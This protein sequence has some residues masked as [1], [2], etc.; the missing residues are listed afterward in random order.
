M[1]LL[2]SN[3]YI[4][5]AQIAQS[6]IEKIDF[7]LCAGAGT[8]GRQTLEKF[9]A[10]NQEK[11][12]LVI[13]GGFFNMANGESVFVYKS[14]GKVIMDYGNAGYYNGIG[15]VD[16]KLTYGYYLEKPFYDFATAY[17]PLIIDKKPAASSYLGFND[18]SVN[19]KTRRTAIGYND[20]YVYVV[21]VHN[22]GMRLKELQNLFVEL[23]CD[24][25]VNLDGGGSS[26]MLYEGQAYCTATTGNRAVD[27]VIAFYLKEDKKEEVITPSVST[28]LY[29]VQVGAYSSKTNANK[30]LAQVKAAGYQGAY[31]RLVGNLYKVQVGAF[32]KREN[33]SKLMN[34]LKSKGFNAF[35]A[36]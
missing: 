12:Q 1:K 5:I 16:G 7:H 25:A 3:D 36:Q 21:C 23:G 26:R 15:T 8:G 27:N 9:Y 31:V 20:E 11:P 2:K 24:Y 29:R 30:M 33:A 22:P 13:N 17:P 10:Q 6:E 35:I 4:Y 19:T 34:E 28:P 14:K 18:G 32:S